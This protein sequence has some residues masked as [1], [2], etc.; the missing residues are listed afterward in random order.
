[1]PRAPGLF[2]IWQEWRARRAL[3]ERARRYVAALWTE[4]SKADVDWL[5]A[6]ATGGDVDHARWELRYARRAL[7]L[8]AAQR[9]ALDDRTASVVARALGRALAADP[10]VAPGKLK[11]AERQLNARLAAYREAIVNR[12]GAG[13]GWHLG[14]ALLRF[15]GRR[16]AVDP[17]DVAQAGDVAARYLEEANEA[18]REQFG[19][20]ALPEDVA[21][22]A[23][24]SGAR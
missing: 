23:L 18:L 20:A 6:R 14:R 10:N 15:A 12:E 1:M 17:A 24:G 3:D 19:A 7:C 5:A 16:D 13:T 21:P 8:L 2:T 4:P 11:V 22:S 9:D